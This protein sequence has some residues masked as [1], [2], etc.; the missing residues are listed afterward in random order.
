MEDKT[1]E[2]F[3]K[4][5]LRKNSSCATVQTYGR[6]EIKAI[7]TWV[8]SLMRYGGGIIAWRKDELKSLGKRTRKLMTMNKELSTK[9]DVSRE[10]V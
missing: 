1:K 10:Y 2:T 6:N 7:N 4:E 9:K 5:Y 3:R 8:T